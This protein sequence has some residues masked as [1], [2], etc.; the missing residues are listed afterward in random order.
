MF[1]KLIKGPGYE[2]EEL[3]DDRHESEDDVDDVGQAILAELKILNGQVGQ[4]IIA[5]KGATRPRP[6]T[7][8]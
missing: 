5:F 4:L 7:G 1:H 6:T 3:T 8:G 2:F